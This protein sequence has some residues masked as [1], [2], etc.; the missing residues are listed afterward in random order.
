[1]RADGQLAAVGIEGGAIAPMLPS[2]SATEA[3]PCWQGGC[4]WRHRQAG[5]TG[6]LVQVVDNFGDLVAV[7]GRLRRARSNPH[8]AFWR[9]GR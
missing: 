6:H 5:F 8:I 7:S 3:F 1:M 9:G 4:C 2:A